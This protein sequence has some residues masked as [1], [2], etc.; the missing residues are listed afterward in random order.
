MHKASPRHNG[1]FIAMNC[2]AIPR[3]LIESE[4]F[5][6]RKGAFTGAL[7]DREG[8][9]ALADGGTLF[10]DELCEMDLDLQAKL[11]RFIQTGSY[12]RVGDG[13]DRQ[14]DIRFVCATNRDPLTEVAAGRFREDLYY[15][16]VLCPSPC[17]PGDRGTDIS[18][19]ANRFLKSFASERKLVVRHVGH[20]RGGKCWP[21]NVRQ[22]QLRPQCRGAEQW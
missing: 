1:P 3:D 4:M 10:L 13:T 7:Q 12:R 8:A 15:R 2:A 22:L 21:G 18:L 5:G 6:H 11:L 16:C 14:V 9:A 20:G 19:L 17:R